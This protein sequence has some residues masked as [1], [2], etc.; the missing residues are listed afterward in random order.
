MRA[1][2]K[3]RRQA[4]VKLAEK[5]SL[6]DEEKKQT[7]LIALPRGGVEVAT[8]IAKALNLPL[9]VLI[10]RK[11]G[12]PLYSEYG[13]GAVTED[14]FS[15]LDEEALGVE[16]IPQATLDELFQQAKNEVARR[17][18][19]YRQ[20]RPL[21][22]I[23]NKIVIIVDDGL[24][25]GVTARLAARYLRFRDAKKVILAVPVCVGKAD[26]LKHEFDQVVCL[27]ESS[28]FNSV[29]QFFRSFEQLTD[30][31]VI[32]MLNETYK[33]HP[34]PSFDVRQFPLEI[35]PVEQLILKNAVAL[36]TDFDFA[37]IIERIKSAKIVMLGEATHGTREFYEI[38]RWIT[39]QL[40]EHHG[41]NIVAVEGD[42]PACAAVDQY[43]RSKTKF[44]QA[45]EVLRSFRRWPTWMWANT[46]MVKWVQWMK[47]FN[48]IKSYKNQVGFYGLDVYSFFDSVDEVLASLQKI[49]PKMAAEAKQQYACLKPF[50][51]NE[52]SYA[53]S[54]HQRPDGCSKEVVKVLQSLLQLKLERGQAHSLFDIQQNARIVKNAEH[55]YS[56]LIHGTEES[57][58][59]RDHHMLETLNLL[60]K[61]HGPYAKAIVW[62]HNSHVG[63]HRATDM[64]DAKHV[65]LGGLAREEWGADKVVLIGLGTYRG[66]VT[67]SRAWDGPIETIVVPPAYEHTYEHLFHHAAMALDSNSLFLWLKDELKN[68]ELKKVRGHR[69]IGVVYNP[70]HERRWNDVP[71]SLTERYDGFL[72]V[73]QTHALTA[74]KQKFEAK[75]I[76]ETWPG[77]F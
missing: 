67:A 74:L 50:Q 55:Y 7:V 17:K 25:T 72:F 69:A 56:A 45:Y 76:P 33:K 11:V 44:D 73:D 63:D 22:E 52:K 38:R 62:A 60:L 39:Q 2:L 75:D 47:E 21:I 3:D 10:V 6:S 16:K 29:G 77:G 70:L 61:K 8:E 65:S 12:H 13:I 66:E 32:A 59:I 49:D 64:L 37:K 19:Q 5:I 4:G 48:S 28:Q 71:T 31:E 40:V 36:K 24:A 46:D 42:W 27:S 57:W 68:S 41:F 35:R 9:D 34:L 1:L 30:E 23:E 14:D 18:S 15:W 26:H 51:R 20:D 54:L 58:N 43:V 53:R